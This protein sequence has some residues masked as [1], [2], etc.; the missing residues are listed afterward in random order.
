M[1][2]YEDIRIYINIYIHTPKN[3]FD[4]HKYTLAGQKLCLLS[5][6]TAKPFPPRILLPFVN[7]IL[8]NFHP[9]KA[10]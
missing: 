10:F 1:K 7:M 2:T 5:R 3:N 8:V 6:P 9:G 4:K